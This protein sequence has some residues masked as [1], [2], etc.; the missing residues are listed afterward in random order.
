MKIFFNSIKQSSDETQ[1]LDPTIFITDL[2]E[3]QGLDSSGSV[4]ISYSSNGAKR[5]EVS[6]ISMS[7]YVEKTTKIQV[8]YTL[9]VPLKFL[10]Q[11]TWVAI[12]V[13]I[14]TSLNPKFD[15]P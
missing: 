4:Y 10:G 7:F 13:T 15:V 9:T 14:S 8:S 12:P 6:D 5:Y 1:S 11:T 3:A 2:C